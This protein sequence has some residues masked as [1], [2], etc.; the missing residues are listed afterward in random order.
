MLFAIGCVVGSFFGS[1]SLAVL[2]NLTRLPFQV[3][4]KIGGLVEDA[5]KMAGDAMKK[6]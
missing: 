5:S 4:G 1:F 3:T 2:C 6:D